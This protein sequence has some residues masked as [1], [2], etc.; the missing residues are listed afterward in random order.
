MIALSEID[1]LRDRL[2]AKLDAQQ[3]DVVRLHRYY[4]GDHDLPPVPEKCNEDLR[5]L[6]KSSILN[7][8][9]LVVDTVVER[10]SVVG[11]SFSDEPAHDVWRDMW[12]ANQLDADQDLLYAEACIARR[13]FLLV[14]PDED[15]V[16]ITPESPMEVAVTYEPGSRRKR[17]AAVK[18]FA[19]GDGRH[20]HT[21]VTV[22]TPEGVWRWEAKG[23]K[24]RPAWSKV[25]D[26]T[27]ENP[28]GR[29][30]VVELLANP[31]LMGTPHSELDGGVIQIQDRI[32]KTIY[33]RLVLAEYHAF[34]QRWATGIDVEVDA[35]GNPVEP[36]KIGP[37]RIAVNESHE[38]KFG[39]WDAADLSGLLN[40]ER[41]EVES[42]AV[43]TSTP[44]YT[45]TG[46]L[47]DIKAEVA[48]FAEAA[49]VKKAERYQRQFGESIE[50]AIRLALTAMKDPR[51][52][53]VAC[54]VEWAD[55]EI[56]TRAGEADA[57]VKVA[58]YIPEEERWRR[59]GYSP[60]ERQRFRSE[61][62][63]QALLAE[64]E[65]EPA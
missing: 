8:C 40:A 20:K 58:E 34:P 44:Q 51:A 1:D 18:R 59:L 32:N 56:R 60:Q 49:L 30:P 9:D 11:F 24:A 13:S 48:S 46:N 35:A 39:Q 64:P 36:F 33:D 15:G 53:D 38:V 63:T 4:D 47:S 22:W 21:D 65:P 50:E 6:A 17:A 12:Q 16:S 31:D 62:A 52:D 28:F 10:L 19:I 5:R 43:K 61:M 57:L 42:M 14:W 26:G 29:V 25:P 41:A 7:L 3:T 37:N 23:S 45:F 2:L 55:P 54:E 27:G